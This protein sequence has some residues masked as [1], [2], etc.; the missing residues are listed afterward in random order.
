MW[1]SSS[2]GGRPRPFSDGGTQ[3][4]RVIAHEYEGSTAV[5]IVNGNGLSTEPSGKFQHGGEDSSV[6][7]L[8]A[9]HFGSKDDASA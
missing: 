2:P 5:R 4:E 7:L 3:F 6:L 9:C 1:R 8:S